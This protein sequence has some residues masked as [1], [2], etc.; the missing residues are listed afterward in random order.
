M[1]E[2][3]NTARFYGTKEIKQFREIIRNAVDE[4]NKLTLFEGVGEVVNFIAIDEMLNFVI[5]PIFKGDKPYDMPDDFFKAIR[6]DIYK[7]LIK[8]YAMDDSESK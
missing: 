3:V 5:D 7:K 2:K 6:Q 8:R 4:I 1:R